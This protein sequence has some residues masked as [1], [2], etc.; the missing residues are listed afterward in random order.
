LR[1]TSPRS[2]SS[3]LRTKT[4]GGR[5]K[6]LR[7]I[8]VLDAADLIAVGSWAGLLG[9]TVEADDDWHTVYV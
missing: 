4:V 3:Q 7:T 8:V 2:S 5:L 6:D 9:G 1:S